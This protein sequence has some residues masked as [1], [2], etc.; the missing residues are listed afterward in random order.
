MT[1]KIS[2]SCI[3]H[4]NILVYRCCT[5]SLGEI[6]FVVSEEMF[7]N[8]EEFIL[9]SKQ[10]IHHCDVIGPRG[11]F[12]PFG[13]HMYQI[14]RLKVERGVGRPFEFKVCL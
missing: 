3:I 6:G 7:K 11:K 8:V 1:F 9:F 12:V 5:A 10:I 4:F 2:T 14:P 13:K